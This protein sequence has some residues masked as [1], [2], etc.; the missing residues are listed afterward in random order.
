MAAI[1]LGQQIVGRA[2]EQLGVDDPLGQELGVLVAAAGLEVLGLGRELGLDHPL[3]EVGRLVG[4]LAEPRAEQPE[5]QADH[6][7]DDHRPA[8]QVLKPVHEAA[9]R[10]EQGHAR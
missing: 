4:D 7:Q 1:D 8:Q 2:E 10:P 5:A 3:A 9:E 6:A